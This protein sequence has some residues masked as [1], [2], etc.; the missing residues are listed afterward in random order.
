MLFPSVSR[1][2]ALFEQLLILLLMFLIPLKV[3]KLYENLDF[4]A[5]NL[6]N[7]LDPLCCLFLNIQQFNL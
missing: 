6:F 3:F 2:T 1:I 5:L 4:V 7:L